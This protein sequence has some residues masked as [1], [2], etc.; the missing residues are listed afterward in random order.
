M[1]PMLH[2]D[3]MKALAAWMTWKC[4]IVNIPFG[5]AKGGIKCDPAKLSM[6]ELERLTRRFTSNLLDVFGPEKRYS[7][8]RYEYK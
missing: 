3:E 7:C 2:L 1:H 6:N 5:G 8:S 4:A